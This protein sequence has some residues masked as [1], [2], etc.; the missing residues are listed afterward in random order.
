MKMIDNLIKCILIPLLLA[1]VLSGCGGSGGDST[2]QILVI[3]EGYDE[4]PGDVF[5]TALSMSI[6]YSNDQTAEINSVSVKT[7]SQVDEIP[8]KYNYSNAI[9]GPYLLETTN[10]DG[11]LDGLE[12]MTLSGN[13]IIDD[14]LDY[15]TNVEYTTESGSEDPENIYIGDK[16]SFNENATLFNSQTGLEAG[17]KIIKMEFTVLSEEVVSVPAGEFNTAKIGYSISETWS[18]NNVIDTLSGTGYGWFDTTNSYMIKMTAD[19]DMT[20]NEYSLTASFSSEILL[21]SY[22]I[23]P[24]VVSNTAARI[25]PINTVPNAEINADLIFFGLKKGIANIQ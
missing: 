12:Y 13:S 14:D 21:Q 3:G 10:E 20:L 8:L 24:S 7:Y 17:Y 1:V 5:T 25:I 4:K 22:F 15:F 9:S 18:K 11:V 16:Y 23:S 19:G 6:T 2:N